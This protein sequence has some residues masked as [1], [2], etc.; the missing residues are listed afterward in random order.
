MSTYL[1]RWQMDGQIVWEDPGSLGLSVAML[2]QRYWLE[3]REAGRGC[4]R[5]F[6]SSATIARI[7][8]RTDRRFGDRAGRAYWLG[9][10]RSR[11]EVETA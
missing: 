2:V 4:D 5:C 6:E 1:R 3:G 8:A 10:A 7:Y 11:R 9:F